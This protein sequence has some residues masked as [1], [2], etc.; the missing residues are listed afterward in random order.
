MYDP[1]VTQRAQSGSS[2]DQTVGTWPT[3]WGRMGF[4]RGTKGLRRV[5]LPHYSP[6]DLSDLLAWEHPGAS[7]DDEA[8]A[9]LAALCRA[10]FNG[11]P[12]DFGPVRCDLAAVGPFARRILTACRRIGYGR[13]RTY[14]QLARM[15][16]EE[17]KARAAARALG[18]NPVPLVVPC[19]R[20]VAAGGGLGGFSAAGGVEL[21][22]RMIELEGREPLTP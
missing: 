14:S 10:Y 2:A 20:V 5:V 19:H 3:P 18:S 6:R 11:E 4:V 7:V 9:E 13:T 21:K 1:T 17:G 15:A 16:D 22:R 8:F 12:V